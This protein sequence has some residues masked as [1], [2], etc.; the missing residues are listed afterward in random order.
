MFAQKPG[1]LTEGFHDFPLSLKA[2]AGI[3]SD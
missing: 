3:V 1:I 2:V